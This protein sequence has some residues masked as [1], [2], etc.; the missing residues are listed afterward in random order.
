MS[1]VSK[2]NQDKL[3][4]LTGLYYKLKPESLQ[5]YHNINEHNAG[6]VFD[7]EREVERARS[8]GG[9]YP[10]KPFIEPFEFEEDDYNIQ[11]KKFRITLKDI[12]LYKEN[13]DNVTEL[14]TTDG[15]T[16]TIKETI[17]E[18]DKFFEE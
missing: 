6:L 3:V 9:D 8:V 4:Q 10:K 17:D 12:F 13:I 7:W 16:F 11:E 5:R 15:T 18:I 14:T 2:V 1:E